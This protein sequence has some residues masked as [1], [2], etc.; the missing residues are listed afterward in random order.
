MSDHSEIQWTDATWNPTT[1]CTKVSPGCALLESAGSSALRVVAV[2]ECSRPSL[3]VKL[4][5]FAT[6]AACTLDHRIRLVWLT[7][8][9]RESRTVLHGVM[10][11]R[12]YDLQVLVSIVGLVAVLVVNL[13]TLPQRPT[14]HFERHEAVFVDVAAH[15]GKWVAVHLDENVTVRCDCSAALPRRA[16]LAETDDSHVGIVYRVGGRNAY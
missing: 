7:P 2:D 4:W 8:A 10:F 9:I 15:V 5:Q 11:P 12:R 1:G 6:A 14:E 13:L 16:F 3:I